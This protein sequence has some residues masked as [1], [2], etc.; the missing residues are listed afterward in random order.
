MSHP[1][2]YTGSSDSTCSKKIDGKSNMNPNGPRVHVL[3]LAIAIK[4]NNTFFDK[5]SR[6]TII[7]IFKIHW[8][9]I[10]PFFRQLGLISPIRTK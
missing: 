5:T 6:N 8:Y 1:L 7:E 4:S 9:K 3:K 2:C 10:Q